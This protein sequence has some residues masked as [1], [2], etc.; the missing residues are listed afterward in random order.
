LAILSHHSVDENGDENGLRVRGNRNRSP[1][2]S[3]FSFTDSHKVTNLFLHGGPGG[4]LVYNFNSNHYMLWFLRS[5]HKFFV[6]SFVANF[7]D[8]AQ[9]KARDKDFNLLRKVTTLIFAH[10]SGRR[11]C[12]QLA[13]PL[14]YD[15][16]A[17]QL[18]EYKDLVPR[19]HNWS[20]VEA[21]AARVSDLLLECL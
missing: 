9:N 16:E 2:S 13:K 10:P 11:A 8:K 17:T 15:L 12:L 1:F 3:P 7:V 18:S 21:V 14:P 6:A 4:W 20:S 19:W 5:P